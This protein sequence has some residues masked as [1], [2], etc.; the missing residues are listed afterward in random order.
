VEL[1]NHVVREI[2]GGVSRVAQTATDAI[3]RR[4]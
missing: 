4:T 3:A 1:V 2:A